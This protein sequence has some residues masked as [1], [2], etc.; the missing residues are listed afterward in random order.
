VPRYGGYGAAIATSAALVCESILLF[1]L[2]KR[3]LG[4]HVFAFGGRKVS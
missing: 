1:I 4:L 3:K 2:T